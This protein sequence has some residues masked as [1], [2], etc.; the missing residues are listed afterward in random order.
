MKEYDEIVVIPNEGFIRST[1]NPKAIIN[2]D[3]E[4]LKAYKL[5]RESSKQKNNEINSLRNEVNELK[6][7]LYKLLSEKNK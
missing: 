4:A 5:Q 1:T 2:V 7:L 3:N 6:E